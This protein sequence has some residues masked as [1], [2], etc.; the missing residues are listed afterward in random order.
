M[1]RSVLATVSFR[2]NGYMRTRP[3]SIFFSLGAE[4][5]V[6]KKPLMGWPDVFTSA[7]FTPDTFTQ[8][9]SHPAS[10]TRGHFHTET[11]SHTDSF[12]YRLLHIVQLHMDIFTQIILD[13]TNQVSQLQ[14]KIKLWKIAFPE[15]NFCHEASPHIWAS[16][17]LSPAPYL[18]NAALKPMT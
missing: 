4:R 9:S 17:H 12:T 5:L 15:D 11:V 10:F 3:F 13:K 1:I 16:G 7:A 2:K 8:T 18:T 6:V 14:K